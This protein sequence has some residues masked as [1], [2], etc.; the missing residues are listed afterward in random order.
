MKEGQGGRGWWRPNRR[1]RCA[2]VGM[3][4]RRLSHF[5]TRHHGLVT[6]GVAADLGVSRSAWYR[7]IESGRLDP[8]APGV[9]RLP[10]APV[11]S[12]QRI[13]AAVWSAG[14]GAVASHRSAALLW[15][16]E[17]PIDDPVDVSLTDRGRAPAPP[18]V[19]VHRPRDLRD[20]RP[21]VRSGVPTTSPL[22]ML[23][24]LGAVDPAGVG[25]ALDHL[26]ANR[27]VLPGAVR[28]ALDRHAR[29]GRHGVRALRRVLDHRSI[30]GQAADSTLEV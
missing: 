8:V 19:V 23:V 5:A 15:G 7:A 6:I 28:S 25:A 1:V 30:G 22:R 13:L 21:I 2:S 20:L 14:P 3:D 9:A 12:P 24:D 18:N 26:V 11:T 29:Q 17:R 16:V 4:V 10:G 27:F